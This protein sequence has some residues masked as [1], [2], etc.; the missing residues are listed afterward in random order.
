MIP[1][2]KNMSYEEDCINLICNPC[3]IVAREVIL[4]NSPEIT[5]GNHD[6]PTILNF[7]TRSGLHRH[8]L[9]LKKES[10][11]TSIGQ[12]SLLRE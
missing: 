7:D 10:I 6:I 2:V 4:W 8:C 12:L 11:M 5:H 9:K 1:A 3:I